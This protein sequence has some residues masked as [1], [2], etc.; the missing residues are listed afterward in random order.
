VAG[1]EAE[2]LQAADGS[3]ER[4]TGGRGPGG[5]L[6][7]FRVDTATGGR[8]ELPPEPSYHPT[9]TERALVG[10]TLSADCEDS[11]EAER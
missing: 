2:A 4:R 3:T 5:T 11:G 10:G 9:G 6:R 7:S 1:R 8:R